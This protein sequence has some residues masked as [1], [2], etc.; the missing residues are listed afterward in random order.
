MDMAKDDRRVAR[1]MT[2]PCPDTA[3]DVTDSTI[4]GEEKK[5]CFVQY[6]A[7]P[8]RTYFDFLELVGLCAGFCGL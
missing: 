2:C 8:L 7:A 1:T 4:E 6:K 3:R 5:R